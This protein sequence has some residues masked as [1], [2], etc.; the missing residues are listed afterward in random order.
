MVHPWFYEATSDLNIVLN[1][2]ECMEA[3]PPLKKKGIT[4]LSQFW[5]NK[6]FHR[7]AIYKL[8]IQ[9]FL[10]AI[11][12]FPQNCEI[13]TC[14]CELMFSFEGEADMFSELRAT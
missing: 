9:I 3:F 2:H 4:T 8:A 6:I 5:W 10:L 1:L 7:I 12:T 13:W 14:N 11:A